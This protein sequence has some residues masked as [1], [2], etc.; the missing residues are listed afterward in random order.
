MTSTATIL[1]II[2]AF[3]HAGWNFLS[4]REYPTQAFY[5]VTSV[6]GVL[7][8]LPFLFYYAGLI[9]LVPLPVWIMAGLSGFFLAV[10]YGCLAG[11]YQAGDIS[12]AYP[13]ARSL[14]VFFVFVCTHALGRGHAPGIYFLM[15]I[16][17]IVGGCILLPLKAFTHLQLS[18]YLNK[19]CMLAVLAAVA[20]AGYTLADDTALRR[21]AA[22]PGKPISPVA[23]SLLYLFLEATSCMLWQ[24]LLVAVSKQERLSL[25][26][27]LKIHK[28]SAAV[29]GVGIFLTYAI[30]LVAMNYVS[31]ISYVAALRQ[32]SIP[33]GALM[34][35]VLLK[36][37]PFLPKSIGIGAIFFGLVLAA[38]N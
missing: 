36:E 18:N 14:P 15:G 28:R 8:L 1:L 6:L 21:L 19:C 34:G 12:I 23:S 4:K 11:A 7:F 17:L 29:T 30:V 10:Y 13:L 33:I 5:L 22:L 25:A 26:V 2:S 24:S 3:T 37:P 32:L 27:V 31:N 35:I 38:I 9:S 16:L 20:I